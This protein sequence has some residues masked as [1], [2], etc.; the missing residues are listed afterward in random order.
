MSF[1]IA[2]ELAVDFVRSD[3]RLATG[4]DGVLGCVTVASTPDHAMEVHL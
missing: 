2:G 3:Q 1:V 4:F